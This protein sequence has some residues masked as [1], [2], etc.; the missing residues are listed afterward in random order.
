MQLG[1]GVP[2]QVR[3]CHPYESLSYSPTTCVHGLVPKS[4][5]LSRQA[6]QFLLDVGSMLAL[7]R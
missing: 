6:I 2:D 5:Q 1:G 3:G 7:R 4:R